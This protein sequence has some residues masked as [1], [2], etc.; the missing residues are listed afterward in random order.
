MKNIL[1]TGATGYI[2]SRLVKRFVNEGWKTSIIIRPQSVLDNLKDIIG[3]ISVYNHN[4]ST[5]AIV[6]IINDSKPDIVL[7]VAA[8]VV[9]RDIYDIDR[10]VDS[11][12]SFGT[13]L[14]EAM[15]IFGVNKIINTGTYW[16]NCNGR[17]YS[18][19][20]LY[21]ATKEA[22]VDILKYYVESFGFSV[23]SLKLFDTYGPNDSRPKVFYQLNEAIKRCRPL[24]MT[25]GEQELD[26]VYVDDVVEAYVMAAKR[27]LRS[28]P[29]T[30]EEFDV[31][32]GEAT[33]L[34]EIVRLYLEYLKRN[35]DVR[36]GELDYEQRQIMK[37]VSLNE[38]LPGWF[39]RMRLQDGLKILA[40]VFNG[41]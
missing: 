3:N 15:A 7:H 23:I 31:S 30:F 6:S 14:L 32:S 37:P 18:A 36:W 19:V 20:N 4:N 22:F 12:I 10:L 1:V 13:K 17:D 25:K 39:P 34:K 40:K 5:E 35:C 28:R 21:A 8:R 29:S 16:Q 26:L 2:G 9:H 24:K 27:L 33:K 41:K 11:N 38:P